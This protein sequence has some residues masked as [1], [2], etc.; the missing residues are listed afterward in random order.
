[1]PVHRVH[2]HHW[3]HVRT[4]CEIVAA[5]PFA[6]NL[7]FQ[8]RAADSASI[9]VSLFGSMSL[10]ARALP[11]NVDAQARRVPHAGFASKCTFDL[12]AA[13]WPTFRAICNSFQGQK[14]DASFCRRLVLLPALLFGM[15]SCYSF[16]S[17]DKS[18]MA[19]VDVSEC[20]C[21]V[22][23]PRHSGVSVGPQKA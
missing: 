6:T 17:R 20:V 2:R 22:N 23:V 1:M 12:F 7:Q 8:R 21:S 14:I 5:V 16:T 19:C 10:H 15:P 9:P 11:G 18:T 4:P 13:R 3:Q